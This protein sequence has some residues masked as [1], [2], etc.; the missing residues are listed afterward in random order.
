[1]DGSVGEFANPTVEWI[2]IAGNGRGF[3]AF[4]L[5]IQLMRGRQARLLSD[6]QV[7][8]FLGILGISIAVSP[9]P[10]RW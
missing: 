3:A 9:R 5:Y 8:A 4:V 6:S 2:I 10:M 7:Q 1:M